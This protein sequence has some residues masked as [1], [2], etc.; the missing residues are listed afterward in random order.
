MMAMR[1][2]SGRSGRRRGSQKPGTARGSPPTAGAAGVVVEGGGGI[3]GCAAA[4]CNRERDQHGA[5]RDFDDRRAKTILP[6]S[7]WRMISARRNRAR[8]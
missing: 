5:E 1:E 2:R 8:P 6:T 3:A 7:S 4:G